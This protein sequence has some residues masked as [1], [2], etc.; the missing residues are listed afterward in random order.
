MKMKTLSMLAGVGAPL[1]ATAS[2]SAGFVG[3]NTVIKEN[4]FGLLVVNVYAEFDRPGEDFMQAVAG[5]ANAP[6]LIQVIGGTF[7]T[8]TKSLSLATGRS[9]QHER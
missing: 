3:I 8:P 9:W 7:F 6:M 2:A 1:I 4:P 5:T